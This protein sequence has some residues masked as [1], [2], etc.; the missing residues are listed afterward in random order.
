M[1]FTAVLPVKCPVCDDRIDVEVTIVSR[2]VTALG[3]THAWDM[4][5]SN[6]TLEQHAR[7]R[8]TAAERA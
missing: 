8:H 5:A 2:T 7:D 1:A 3:E 6:E 4:S